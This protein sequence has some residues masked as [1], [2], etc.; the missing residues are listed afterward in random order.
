MNEAQL[1]YL[2]KFCQGRHITEEEALQ[3]VLVRDV[4]DVLK[5]WHEPIYSTSVQ[6]QKC[7]CS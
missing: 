3:H 1:E 7:N 6:Q 2:R 4:L 5:D